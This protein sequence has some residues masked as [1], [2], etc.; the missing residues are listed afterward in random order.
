MQSVDDWIKASHATHWT[1]HEMLL[2]ELYKDKW[3]ALPESLRIKQSTDYR[4]RDLW[5][6]VRRLR[7]EDRYS[8]TPYSR[9]KHS[10]RITAGQSVYF[11]GTDPDGPLQVSLRP[12]IV[13][14]YSTYWMPILASDEDMAMISL[15]MMAHEERIKK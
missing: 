15:A 12:T 10:L 5:C 11:T 8:Y 7:V 4:Y 6:K 3:I 13:Q 1:R 14:E 2:D 9:P